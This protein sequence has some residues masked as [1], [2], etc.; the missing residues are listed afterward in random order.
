MHIPQCP[1]DAV[2]VCSFCGQYIWRVK[3]T[4]ADDHQR[5]TDYEENQLL[6]NNQGKL[7]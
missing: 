7:L 6:Y 2:M 5:W 3:S 4:F 1:G